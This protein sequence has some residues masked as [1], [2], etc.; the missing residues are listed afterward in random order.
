MAENWTKLLKSCPTE[1]WD[2]SLYRFVAKNSLDGKHPPDYLFT[3]GKRNRCNPESIHC[4]YVAGEK[5]SALTE[6]E[7]YFPEVPPSVL[8]RVELRARAVIDLSKSATQKHLGIT[9]KDLYG[10]FR[11]SKKVT[12]LESLGKAISGQS[13]ICAIKFPSA[14]CREAKK[15][16]NNFVI[17][18]DALTDPDYLQVYDPGNSVPNRWP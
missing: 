12:P 10:S 17:F 1:P 14:A 18:K 2:G 7:K 16:G 5:E 11:L 6:F 4:I 9:S 3:S 13:K 15:H 8:Y